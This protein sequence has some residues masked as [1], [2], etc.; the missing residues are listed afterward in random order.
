[1]DNE[2]VIEPKPAIILDMKPDDEIISVDGGTG[3]V[4]VQAKIT[5]KDK[6]VWAVIGAL[7]IIITV[8]KLTG[9]W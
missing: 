7:I 5:I 6:R 3:D 9:I 4:T 1:M 8:C 2:P